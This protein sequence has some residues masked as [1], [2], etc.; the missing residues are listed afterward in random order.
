MPTAGRAPAHPARRGLGTTIGRRVPDPLVAWGAAAFAVILGFARLSYGLLLPALREALPGSYGAFGLVGSANLAGYLVGTLAVPALLRR[1]R[2][3]ARL[4]TGALLGTGIAMLGSAT[5][6]DLIQL[7]A[8]RFLIGLCSGVAAV[9]TI[10]L[11]LD[12][13]APT[14]RGRTSGRLWAGGA[15]GVALSGVAAPLVIAAGDAPTWRGAWAAMAAVAGVAAYGFHRALQATAPDGSPGTAD[16]QVRAR[17]VEPWWRGLAE[18]V[19][20]RGLLPLT[21]AYTLFGGGYIIYLTFFV[22]LVVD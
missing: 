9:L 10:A 2:D 5:S 14:A 21:L 20:P 1:D 3:R 11:T 17:A 12:R 22:A 13:V 4:N 8:W 15:A 19:R 18:L 6:A 7:G 16:P